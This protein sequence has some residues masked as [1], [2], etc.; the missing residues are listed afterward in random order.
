MKETNLV[1]KIMLAVSKTGAR[2]FRNNT[3]MGYQGKTA[4]KN[5]MI[6]IKHPRVLHAGLCEGSSDLIGWTPVKITPDMVGR[7][8]A[9]FTA[10]EVK[11]K[12]GRSTKDQRAFISQ[13]KESGGIAGIARSEKQATKLL[14]QY[15][16]N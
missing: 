5:G 11:T 7:E 13:I 10:I 16:Q 1:K 12:G 6:I 9:V 2:I 8:V 14:S 4:R 15:E 3:G